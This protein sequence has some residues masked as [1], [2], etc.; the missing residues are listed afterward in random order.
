MSIASATAPGVALP[1][2]S[3]ES[4]IPRIDYDR[5]Q[6]TVVE[7]YQGAKVCARISVHPLHTA[8][9]YFLPTTKT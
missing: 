4:Y 1:P 6:A 2:P 8:L 5:R 9:R 3:V 7:R